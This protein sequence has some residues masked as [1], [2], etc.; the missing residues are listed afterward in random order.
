MHIAA[1]WCTH[2]MVGKTTLGGTTAMNAGSCGT[3]GGTSGARSWLRG[4]KP[5]FAAEG[6]TCLQRL[7]V[8]VC[9]SEHI[10]LHRSKH[11]IYVL[12]NGNSKPN[13][14]K[15]CGRL[16]ESVHPISRAR[17]A[18][19]T[20]SSVPACWPNGQLARKAKCSPSRTA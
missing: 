13:V 8:A 9:L 6:K 10:I 2:R 11:H 15:S 1:Q 4:A 20:S 3:V 7:D 17:F 5:R 16:T 19:I 18:K 12:W 14:C